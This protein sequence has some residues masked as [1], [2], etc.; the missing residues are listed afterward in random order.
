MSIEYVPCGHVEVAES[1]A[2]EEGCGWALSQEV[3][4]RFFRF[5]AVGTNLSAG[6]PDGV[7]LFYN[8]TV[9]CNLVKDHSVAHH[10]SGGDGSD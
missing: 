10:V 9:A 4:N 5:F 3:L 7:L 2:S 6:S 1:V 8:S